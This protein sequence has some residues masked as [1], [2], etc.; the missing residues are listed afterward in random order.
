MAVTKKIYREHPVFDEF[1]EFDLETGTLE[2]ISG[3]RFAQA[4]LANIRP[5]SGTEPS[6][7]RFDDGEFTV[8][9][10]ER[11]PTHTRFPR[12][13]YFQITR[14]CNLECSYCFIKARSGLSHVPVQDIT[15]IARYM[16][17]NGLMEVRLTGGEPTTHPGFLSIVDVF[18]ENGV[19]VSVA[20]N[21]IMS[22]KV[23]DG[24]AERE[25]L[26]VICSVEGAREKHN[27]FRPGTFDAIMSNLGY[28]KEKNPEIRLRLTTVLTR[29][30][31]DQMLELGKIVKSL[32][33]ESITVI[34]LRPQVRSPQVL[35]DM[36]DA[37]EFGQVI[38][39]LVHVSEMLG[40]NVTT[41]I[42]THYAD[43][44]WH[45]PVVRK[46]SSCAAGREATNLDYDANRGVFFVYG[47]SYSPAPDLDAPKEIR[48]PFV[49][50]EFSIDEM[51][52]FYH[53]WQNDR[54][55]AVYRDPSFKSRECQSCEYLLNYQ[56]V[57]SC[58][59]QNV[60]YSKIDADED[61][62]VQLKDQLTRT[63]EWYCYKRVFD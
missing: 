33:A 54:L 44:I 63:A 27:H 30:N 12:R 16:G 57:G 48:R 1:T 23:L 61:V 18:Q 17:K 62:L 20:T 39:D 4:M 8:F 13:I 11:S 46:R 21:G 6:I 41:T 38:Q 29:T 53:I 52:D 60:D 32:D 5:H 22:R 56:C 15:E 19:Y 24:L 50:G 10:G 3:D 31:K 58:P 55:W 26:W 25:N 34:P 47:C 37:Q 59:I 35:E 40:I 36:V 28:L 7:Q 51:S 14:N 9:T 49:A 2:S 42:E 45:D 43:K